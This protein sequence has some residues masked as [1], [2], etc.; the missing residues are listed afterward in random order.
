MATIKHTKTELK[1]Q[2]ERLGRFKRFLPTLQLKKQQLQVEIQKLAARLSDLRGRERAMQAD[3]EDWVKLFSEPFPFADH[4]SVKHVKIEEGNIAGVTIPIFEEVVF[5]TTLPDLYTSP[6]WV[7]DGI[8]MLKFLT[9]IHMELLILDRQYKLL[10]EELRITSQRVNLFE[11]VKIPESQN[12][13]RTIR[14]FLGDQQAAEVARA[15]IAKRI[16]LQK[17]QSL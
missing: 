14:I 17:A 9:S 11:K 15:K 13:I 7:D 2:R 10:S 4:L 1:N 16:A 5:Q 3:L 6:P 8:N 12:N